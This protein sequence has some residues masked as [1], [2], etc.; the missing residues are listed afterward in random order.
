MEPDSQSPGL[1][2][3]RLD[4]IP[5][6]PLPGL[7]VGTIGVG[8]LFAFYDMF[9]INVS[10]IQTCTQIVP[11]CTPPSAAN[12]I[13]LQVLLSLVGYVIGTLILGALADRAG[14]RDLLLVTMLITGIGSVITAVVDTLRSFR[15]SPRL[16]PWCWSAAFSSSPRSLRNSARRHDTGSSKKLRPSQLISLRTSGSGF[17][18]LTDGAEG[19]I[20]APAMSRRKA[21]RKWPC[22]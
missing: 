17:P 1:L 6:W 3:A 11:H 15:F 5:V 10:F 21:R 8:F 4:R 12:Y 7:F 22:T 19:N 16:T 14:R 20:S 2:I 13:G 9:D 18:Q